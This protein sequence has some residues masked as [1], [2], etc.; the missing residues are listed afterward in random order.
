M[1]DIATLEKQRCYAFKVVKQLTM[2]TLACIRVPFAYSNPVCENVCAMPL[3]HVVEK[4]YELGPKL[5][6]DQK[7][8]LV[9]T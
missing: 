8:L 2:K 9:S 3:T 7:R 6:L 5:K 4:C 1:C